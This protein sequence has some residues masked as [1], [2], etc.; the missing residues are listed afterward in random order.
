MKKLLL[1]FLVLTSMIACTTKESK[2]ENSSNNYPA[3]AS[4][5]NLDNSDHINIA[6]NATKAGISFDTTTLRTFYSDNAEIVDNKITQSLNEYIK[7][8]SQVFGSGVTVK[9]DSIPVIWE[10]VRNKE[11][12]MG[13]KNYV[14]GYV[15]ATATRGG[16]KVG[17]ISNFVYAFK[18]GKIVKEWDTYDSAPIVELLK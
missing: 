10:S 8:W 3:N 14:H 12:K 18:D 15:F 13:I 2:T 5:Y 16:K 7:S 6:M 9:L 1:S 17:F 11:D 4:G